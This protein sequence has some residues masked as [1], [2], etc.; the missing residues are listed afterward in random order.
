MENF[1]IGNIN[2]SWKT[3]WWRKVNEYQIYDKYCS[4]THGK[5]NKTR[6]NIYCF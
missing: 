2:K 3:Y 4:E 6:F 5:K 1:I